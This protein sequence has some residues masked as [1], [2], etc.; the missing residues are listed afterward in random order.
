MTTEEYLSMLCEEFRSVVVATV[1][2]DGLPVTAGIDIMMSDENSAYFL[3]GRKTGFYR[4]LR[5]RGALSLTGMKGP[6][7]LHTVTLTVRGKVRELGPELLPLLFEKNL[8]MQK[9]Y[10]TEE[11]RSGLTVFQIFEGTG[12]YVDLSRRPFFKERFRFGPAEE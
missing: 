8:F 9:L 1:D 3:T 12:E 11:S 6:D 4:R 10:P 5:A 7:P 2:E